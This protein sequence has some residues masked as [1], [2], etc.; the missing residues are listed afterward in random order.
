MECRQNEMAQHVTLYD[1]FSLGS[2]VDTKRVLYT[3]G[4]AKIRGRYELEINHG[5]D[6][7]F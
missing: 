5:M 6:P 3:E 2:E 4:A 7:T 1:S